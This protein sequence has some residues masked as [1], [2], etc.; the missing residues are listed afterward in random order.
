MEGTGATPGLGRLRGK[1]AAVTGAVKG[2]RRATAKLFT[3][4]GALLVL[5][6]VDEAGPE[7]LR[8]QLASEGVGVDSLVG[9]ELGAKDAKR[10][11]GATVERFGRVDILVANACV[12]PL[13]P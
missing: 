4:E 9:E 11:I 7:E 3:R 2:I 5:V 8:E 1:S 10:M 12:T 13:R 6:D